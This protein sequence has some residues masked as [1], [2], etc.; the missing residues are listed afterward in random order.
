MDANEKGA[1]LD[2]PI[3]QELLGEAT[4]IKEQWKV[5]QERIKKIEEHK[6]KVSEAVFAKVLSDYHERLEE[7]ISQVMDK[8]RSI[9]RELVSLYEAQKKIASQ[10]E[11]HRHALE[12]IKF[13]NVLGEY[14]EEDYQSKAKEEQD[15]IS[16]FETILSAVNTNISRYE[17][18]FKDEL[19]IL[20]LEEKRIQK[21]AKGEIKKEVEI[22]FQEEELSS[23]DKEFIT[24][25]E[26]PDYFTSQ[27]VTQP[28]D[29]SDIFNSMERTIPAQAMPTGNSRII[30]ISG[31]DAGATY[32]LKEVI[33]FGRAES[34][35]VTLNDAKVSR[36]H[37]KIIHKG[38]E[39]ILID[40]NS[41]NGTFVNGERIEE[42]VLT[43]ND[44]FQIGDSVLQFQL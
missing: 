38:G 17:D 30:I 18:L 29:K 11:N 33:T 34:N 31:D 5:I 10:L 20:S 28:A 16:K 19:E 40:L 2:Y 42:H 35:T 6:G 3:N 44:E 32:P 26:G 23:S 43:N 15:K 22:P 27:D 1:S 9:D 8:K 36:Q 39:Y 13:R 41:S 25:I 21:E 4:Q 37:A 14:S 7:M 24:E 12:E